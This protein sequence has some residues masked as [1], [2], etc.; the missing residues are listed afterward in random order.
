MRRARFSF[1]PM[2]SP[3]SSWA[4][5]ACSSA[6]KCGTRRACGSSA[7]ASASWT[8]LVGSSMPRLTGALMTGLPAKRSL[9]RTSTSTAKITASAAAITAGSKG[10]APEEPWVSTWRSTPIS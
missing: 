4:R 9:P 1:W 7:A 10:F 6:P 5:S 8:I 3:F 2:C